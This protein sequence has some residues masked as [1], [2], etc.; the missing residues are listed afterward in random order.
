MRTT[1]TWLSI[2]LAVL[3]TGLALTAWAKCPTESVD[4]RGQLRCSFKPDYKVLVTLMFR[5]KQLEGSAA[6]T[7]LDI[8]DDSFQGR[9]NFNSFTSYNPLNGHHQCDRRPTSV[10]VRLISA[11]GE[12][13]DRKTL[14]FPNDFSYDEEAGRYKLRSRVVLQG[15]CKP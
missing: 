15:W 2:A 9:V 14:H 4:V 11:E 8:H 12:E 13:W 5:K 6:E 7:A 1:K 3:N 10:L